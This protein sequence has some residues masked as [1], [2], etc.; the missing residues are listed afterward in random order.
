MKNKKVNH[1][2][3]QIG[4][5]IQ[6]KIFIFLYIVFCCLNRIQ[7]FSLAKYLLH[8]LICCYSYISSFFLYYN[9][10]GFSSFLTKII[11]FEVFSF[12]LYK[13]VLF[14]FLFI[15]THNHYKYL[16]FSRSRFQ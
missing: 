8:L 15:Y 9:L 7:T 12:C 6:K 16:V 11:A 2:H 14:L 10:V 13:Y 4:F 1:T 3:K 5:T